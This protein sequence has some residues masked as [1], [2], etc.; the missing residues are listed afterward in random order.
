MCDGADAAR[1]HVGDQDSLGS[2]RRD[3]CVGTG[4]SAGVDYLDQTA[5][6]YRVFKEVWAARTMLLAP[7]QAPIESVEGLIGTT[8]AA[9]DV[10][11][12]EQLFQFIGIVQLIDAHYL[13]SREIICR[14]IDL[15]NQVPA[16]SEDQVRII[17]V[18]RNKARS[19][20]NGLSVIGS[21]QSG[22]CQNH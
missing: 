17:V 11:A 13:Q 15:L 7:N 14:K 1:A 6:K 16:G 2:E 9:L 20:F 10:F 8:Q 5:L 22:G 18:R 21:G 12:T 19:A 3:E 4:G